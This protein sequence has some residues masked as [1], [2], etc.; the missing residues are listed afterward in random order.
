MVVIPE[1][2]VIA[3]GQAKQWLG[4]ETECLVFNAWSGFDVDAFGALSGTVKA[5]GPVVPAGASAEQLAPV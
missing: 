2:E 4:R 5:G 3:A 1:S